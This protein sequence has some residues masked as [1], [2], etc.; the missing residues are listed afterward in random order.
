MSRILVQLLLMI[1]VF[2]VIST[3]AIPVIV[4]NLI[5]HLYMKIDIYEYIH[6]ILIGLDQVGGSILYG[7][8]DFTISS[9]TYILHKKGVTQATFFM[10]FIDLLIGK[11]TS[12]DSHCE[13]AYKHEHKQHL[14]GGV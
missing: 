12:K 14:S 2:I 13:R 3:I 10:R 8:K 4:I 1:V 9:Y 6:A 5:R 11:I 7:T